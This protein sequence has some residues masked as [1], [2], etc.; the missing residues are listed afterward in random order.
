MLD[1]LHGR[2]PLPDALMRGQTTT[3]AKGCTA[4]RPCGLDVEN[5]CAAA[6][7]TK[8][9]IEPGQIMLVLQDPT[10]IVVTWSSWR[11]ARK[12]T[13]VKGAGRA[14]VLDGLVMGRSDV[15][16]GYTLAF[17]SAS[18][19]SAKTPLFEPA[20]QAD[21]A[22]ARVAT[23]RSLGIRAVGHRTLTFDHSRT[24]SDHHLLDLAPSAA[25]A[26]EG[27]KLWTCW[28]IGASR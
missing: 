16:D 13:L 6:L 14:A 9:L 10:N 11:A 24:R 23:N 28:T 12:T 20:L 27:R 2:S 15:A 25:D 8:R 18:R 21:V 4:E 7:E 3:V 1:G 5:H 26:Q 19:R 22:R 17:W